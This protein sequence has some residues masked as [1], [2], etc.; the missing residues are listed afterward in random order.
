MYNNENRAEPEFAP[1]V[2]NE[3]IYYMR[4]VDKEYAL[5]YTELN[6]NKE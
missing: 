2:Y 6:L 1:Y 4:K 3:L 5:P